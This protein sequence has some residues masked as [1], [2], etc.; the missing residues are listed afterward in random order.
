MEYP[1]VNWIDAVQLVV[2]GAVMLFVWLRKPG[3]EAA[4][5]VQRL[6][7]EVNDD[8]GELRESLGRLEERISHMPGSQ[9]VGML[10]QAV[11]SLEA[12][13]KALSQAQDQRT[14]VIERKLS[15]IEE[16]LLN[17]KS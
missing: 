4:E 15:R 5:E 12:T 8:V 9:E 2:T 17:S 10:S 11:A 13:V 1:N 14:D 6:R 7:Q 3:K 16:F